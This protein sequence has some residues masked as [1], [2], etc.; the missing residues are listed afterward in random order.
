MNNENLK[1]QIQ[2]WS[3]NIANNVRWLRVKSQLTQAQM[4]EKI[5]M[6]YR[7]YQNFEGG[8]LNPTVET[9]LKVADSFNV[10][11]DWLTT[12]NSIY[13]KKKF[14]DLIIDIKKVFE[15]APFSVVVRDREYNICYY[16]TYLTKF[17]GYNEEE[18]KTKKTSDYLTKT[19][20]DSVQAALQLQEER[21]I[22]PYQVTGFYG[23]DTP[24]HCKSFPISLVNSRKMNSEATMV[25]VI[26]LEQVSPQLV[27]DYYQRAFDILDHL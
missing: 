17:K 2:K 19:S 9:I 22:Y 23:S 15:D 4:A 14:E 20:Q 13:F 18:F 21:L 12:F 8:K 24:I 25:A 26:P 10:Q 1:N 7:Y 6:N 3:I 16:N 5:G 27:N 11:F